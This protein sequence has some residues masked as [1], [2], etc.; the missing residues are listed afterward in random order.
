MDTLPQNIRLQRQQKGWTQQELGKKLG[1]SKTAVFYWEKGTREPDIATI[2][3]MCV[4]FGVSPNDLYGVV[5]DEDTT[6]HDFQE[7]CDWLELAG[8]TVEQLNE[9]DDYRI[10]DADE[11]EVACFNVH[12]LIRVC[13]QIV[14]QGQELKDSFIV[15]KL[16]LLFSK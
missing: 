7:A 13:Q 5:E 3:Q 4:L 9:Y 14:E 10:L 15:E 1:V 12:D 16:K 6:A 11:K 2:K 8:F